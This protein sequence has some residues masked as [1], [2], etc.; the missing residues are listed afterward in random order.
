MVFLSIGKYSRYGKACF[1]KII[2]PMP[3]VSV[4][5]PVYNVEKFIRRC[6]ISIQQQSLD[7][8][9][10]IVVNDATPDNSM[11]IV[12]ELA[13]DDHRITILNHEKN[14]GPM[15]TRETGYMAATGDYITFCD[16]DDSLPKDALKK[17]YLAA[18]GTN[19][20]IITGNIIYLTISGEEII[21]KSELKY[22]N[23]KVGVLR[24]LLRR[25]LGHNLCGKLFKA[26]LLQEYKYNTYEHATN[27][28]DGCLFYQVIANM[29]LMIVIDE[30]VYYYIQNTESSSQV[31]LTENALASICIANTE[32][33]AAVSKFPELKRDLKACVS[34]SLVILFCQGYDKDGTLSKLINKYS[35][36]DYCS[37]RTIISSHTMIDAAKLL[38]KRYL[39]RRS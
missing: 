20:D 14:M 31:K 5:V 3:K 38:L 27:G 11:A 7:D 1:K 24:S 15:C 21:W 9:E 34:S 23:T 33:I 10:I 39:I 35:L 19:A 37:F 16:S 8:I 25:E 26:S 36:I 18:V 30:V 22:G 13:K 2:N 6:L 29:D 4:I 17:L 12:Q 32:R 28:E